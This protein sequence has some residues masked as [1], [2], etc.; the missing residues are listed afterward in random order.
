M[1]QGARWVVVALAATI[2]WPSNDPDDSMVVDKA[3]AADEVVVTVDGQMRSGRCL[4]DSMFVGSGPVT[5]GDL[6]K[7]TKCPAETTIFSKGHALTTVRPPWTKDQD[8]IVLQMG[9]SLR[10]V[11]VDVYVV[12]TSDRAE[13]WARTDLDRAR[14]L[15]DQNRTGLT[16]TE[17]KFVTSASLSE[18]Q[19]ATIGTNCRQADGLKSSTLYASD[20]INV[21]F[22]PSIM[23]D[24]DFTNRGYNCFEKKPGNTDGAP[25]IIYISV[26]RHSPTTLA[27]ELGHGLGLQGAAGHTG[28]EGTTYIEGFESVNI[29][30]TGLDS[31][32]AAAKDQ[33]SLGQGFRMNADERSWLNRTKASSSPG[34]GSRKCHP[35]G[36]KNKIPCP[37]LAFD[38]P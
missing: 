1:N 37:P 8:A 13:D 18:A 16:F 5:V 17:T 29:M 15:Y 34:P 23:I 11:N 24:Y 3:S 30:W 20:R 31:D 25:N 22:V 19:V 4:N 14:T 6:V 7:P 2:G 32:E 26:L 27:H 21:Y 9:P 33:F 38:L 36:P 10:E 12:S 35:S 28:E